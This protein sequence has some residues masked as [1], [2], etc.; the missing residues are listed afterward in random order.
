MA[1]RSKLDVT[2]IS[3]H[4]FG[5]LR[6]TYCLLRAGGE[7]GKAA[8][9]LLSR[10]NYRQMKDLKEKNSCP[11]ETYYS[12]FFSSAFRS[13]LEGAGCGNAFH[14]VIGAVTSVRQMQV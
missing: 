6:D 12:F 7:L 9:L 1:I 4:A 14:H 2:K 13:V 10:K 11:R 8:G 3:F 5:H